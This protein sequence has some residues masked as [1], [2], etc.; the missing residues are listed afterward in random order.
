METGGA[1][2]YW[3]YIKR[4]KVIIEVQTRRN[5]KDRQPKRKRRRKKKNRLI[6]RKSHLQS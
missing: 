3:I 2:P 5:Q 1:C 4:I 6:L